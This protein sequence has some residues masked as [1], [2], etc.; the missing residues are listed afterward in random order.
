MTAFKGA[1]LQECG[2]SALPPSIATSAETG[3]GKTELQHMLASL[4]IVMEQSGVCESA[5]QQWQR[6]QR[7]A[8]VKSKASAQEQIITPWSQNSS[9]VSSS[10]SS[11]ASAGR[12]TSSSSASSSG[13]KPGVASSSSRGSG[14]GKGPETRVAGGNQVGLSKKSSDSRT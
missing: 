1:L 7:L 5:M 11:A 13:I 10:S 9:G 3:E 8:A 12:S 4:R 14:G 2:F 6:E